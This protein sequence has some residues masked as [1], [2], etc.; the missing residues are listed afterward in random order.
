MTHDLFIATVLEETRRAYLLNSQ[1]FTT[2]RLKDKEEALTSKQGTRSLS[3]ETAYPISQILVVLFGAG[4]SIFAL[5]I[6]PKFSYLQ[7][8]CL[9]HFFL[10]TPSADASYPLS[11]ILAVVGAG[12]STFAFIIPP[13]YSFYI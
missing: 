1:L 11:Q 13:R 2:L 6:P 9:A 4:R 7:I 8:V 12:K 5:M 3:V 10:V